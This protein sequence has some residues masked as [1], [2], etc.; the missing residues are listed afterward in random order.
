MVSEITLENAPDQR[1]RA[2]SLLPLMYGLGSIVGPVLG[3]MYT[4][5]TMQM[6]LLLIS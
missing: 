6:N 3:G 1:A 2:F 5:F 4:S